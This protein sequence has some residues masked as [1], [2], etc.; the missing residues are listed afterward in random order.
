[1]TVNLFK[2]REIAVSQGL[3]LTE[4]DGLLSP[5]WPQIEIKVRQY[6]VNAVLIAH[7]M[8]AGKDYCILGIAKIRVRMFVCPSV[9]AKKS[10]AIGFFANWSEL[11]A[12]VNSWE[13]SSLTQRSMRV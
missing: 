9:A 10:K 7:Y 6:L 12:S 8:F 2:T 13:S 11:R 1:M 4:I 5:S 3:A